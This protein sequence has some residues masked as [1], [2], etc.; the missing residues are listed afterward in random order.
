MSTTKII[1]EVDI[2][3]GLKAAITELECHHQAQIL[4][5]QKE[6]IVSPSVYITIPIQHV[7]QTKKPKPRSKSKSSRRASSKYIKE[8]AVTDSQ[9]KDKEKFDRPKSQYK[10]KEK[11]DRPKKTPRLMFP[12]MRGGILYSR[13]YCLH[14]NGLQ[15][16]C[17]LTQCQGQPEC[18]TEPWAICPPG[19][20][21][22]SRYPELYPTK[23]DCVQR[24]DTK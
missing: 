5:A 3:C 9:C 20:Y 23:K 15:D 2:I 14:R 12:E 7:T 11:L 13:C 21:V 10:D 22:R 1:D 8:P 17:P 19:K 16:V 18:L 24:D 6:K 4:K